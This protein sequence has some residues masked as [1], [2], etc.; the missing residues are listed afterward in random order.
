MSFY[1]ISGS[2]IA[3]FFI[4]DF[5]KKNRKRLGV[6]KPNVF[7]MIMEKIYKCMKKGF[8]KSYIINYI[9]DKI[10]PLED[11]ENY[12]LR[13]FVKKIFNIYYKLDLFNEVVLLDTNILCEDDSFSVEID[14][15][16]RNNNIYF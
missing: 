13:R 9:A 14:M 15:F 8:S 5:E 11:I 16:L 10:T 4:C 2:K 1:K 12:A 7:G 6:I 3:D